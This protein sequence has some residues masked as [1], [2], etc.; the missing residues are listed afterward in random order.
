VEI[1][2]LTTVYD[3]EDRQHQQVTARVLSREK[4]T[5]REIEQQLRAR[6]SAAESM[7]QGLLRGMPGGGRVSQFKG[8]A[9]EI[10]LLSSEA[11]A[12]AGNVSGLGLAVEALGGPLGI[13]A[14]G[15]TAGAAGA[16]LFLN[17]AWDLTKWASEY[18]SSLQDLSQ[19]SNIAVDDL[20]VW[21]VAVETSGG[22][23][24]SVN[25]ALGQYVRKIADVNH[26][27]KQAA[28]D[29][30]Q[31]GI[32]AK[33]AYES[34]QKAIELL[35]N[36]TNQ[37]S[38]EEDRLL[39]LRKAGVRNAEQ[40]NAAISEMGGTYDEFRKKVAAAGLIITPE[41]ARAADQFGD[42]LKYVELQLKAL[43]FTAGSEFFPPFT[44]GL[45]TIKNDLAVLGPL[46]KDW[47]QIT[48]G[49]LTLALS[50]LKPYVDE[51]AVAVHLL[52]N[53]P[54]IQALKA[55]GA[56]QAGQAKIASDFMAGID[57]AGKTVQGALGG[58]ANLG[59]KVGKTGSGESAARKA[60]QQ[61]LQ[62]AQI[63]LREAE[64]VY[65]EAN[66]TARRAYD[67]NLND[68][69]QYVERRKDAEKER[70]KAIVDG[71]QAERRAAESLP[72]AG[73][74][75]VKLKEIG[76]KEADELRKHNET[77]AQLTVDALRH[78]IEV[79]I[80]MADSGARLME[81]RQAIAD[82]DLA[83]LI[84]QGTKTHERA[85]SER[86]AA[87]ARVAEV[88]GEGIRLRLVQ[89]LGG[90]DTV[91]EAG[92]SL[93]DH[94]STAIGNAVNAED[95][96]GLQD[97]IRLILLNAVPKDAVEKLSA[98]L[99]KAVSFADFEKA[100]AD[101]PVADALR[102]SLNLLIGLF[103]KRKQAFQENNKDT[104]D[105]QTEDLNS[106]QSYVRRLADIQQSIT[107]SQFDIRQI[108]IDAGAGNNFRRGA[109]IEAQ[110][111]LDVAR[112]MARSA[113]ALMNLSAERDRVRQT[114]QNERRRAEIIAQIDRQIEAETRLS[115]AKL[116]EIDR[117]AAEAR[118]AQALEVANDIADILSAGGN[119]MGEG[120]RGF[121]HGMLDETISVLQ[122]IAAEF[123][124]MAF[125]ILLSADHTTRGSGAGGL[126]G[127]I[128]NK[129]AGALL[130]G[131]FT[132]AL[133]QGSLT[134][135]WAGNLLTP[136]S[137][138][139]DGGVASGWSVVGERGPE[140]AFFN[141][142]AQI[143]SNQ[144]SKKM[145]G[146]QAVTNVYN[147]NVT[148]KD[149]PVSYSRKKTPNQVAGALL[150]G[151][152]GR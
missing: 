7:T 95:F 67:L 114:E 83:R 76:Q 77:N 4:Q 3:A 137:A 86:F 142:P 34:P 54:Q 31:I 29:F 26:G 8:L 41:Q 32:D 106:W 139:A 119:R 133:P 16:V 109:T 33:T 127:L 71:F 128:T 97:E 56:A 22:N 82:T 148:V 140:L 145:L 129:L 25:T 110:R 116:L 12:G 20:S 143:F 30:R 132:S 49:G 48:A 43:A 123:E 122:R 81:Q 74:R 73:E 68:F 51:I 6:Q 38:N 44:Q 75:T 92:Q 45:D 65:S 19:R 13:V 135:H 35:V 146:G 113:N 24:Q 60:A 40:V 98:E 28:A 103:L 85:V 136:V 27:N 2:R 63:D 39:L 149:T 53:I 69:N 17:K 9:D 108:G 58:G 89:A 138:H 50:L 78:R 36:R 107:E 55:L 72:K 18:A 91:K 111:A 141:S 10:K 14:A 134:G 15:L 120:W 112:E 90:E 121:L 99:N 150:R 47:A 52:E 42:R 37:L 66:A 23:I 151:L 21:K 11:G 79:Q 100:L 101:A 1:G 57:A 144:D 84:E 96:E 61:A 115:S 125:E 102:D 59:D 130:G 87:L 80:R 104:K 93:G 105:A 131:L 124:K 70:Y 147:F 88:E 94:L 126:A 117:Q 46:T 118:R 5:T 152:R 64:S 62:L